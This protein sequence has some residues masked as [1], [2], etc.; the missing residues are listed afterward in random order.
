[1]ERPTT[2]ELASMPEEQR[3]TE[4]DYDCCL[5]S[6]YSAASGMSNWADACNLI[7]RAMGLSGV[8]II[9]LNKHSGQLLFSWEGGHISKECFFDYA[10]QYH[11]QNP[12]LP[13]ALA[14]RGG[15]WFQ[16]H[17]HFDDDFVGINPFYQDFAIPYG[18]RYL[19]A[20]KLIDDK[21]RVV[22]FGALRAANLAPLTQV[23]I[24]ELSRL[25]IHLAQ[26]ATIYL[27]LQDTFNKLTVG[28]DL[29][30]S[31]PYPI[32]TTTLNRE[33]VHQ[34]P[35]AADLMQTDTLVATRQSGF[36]LLDSD[37][38]AAL[39]SRLTEIKQAHDGNGRSNIRKFVI[40]IGR[41]VTEAAAIGIVI[42]PDVSRTSFGMDSLL[43]LLIHEVNQKPSTDPFIVGKIFDLTPAESMVATNLANGS[44]TQAIA[45][46]R[47]VSEHT[48]RAQV[49]SIYTKLNISSHPELTRRL[50]G[51]PQLTPST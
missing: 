41:P 20:T 16:D 21:D 4:E 6:I 38:D 14:L 36:H 49:R 37:G 23:E 24:K 10:T 11:A 8:H 35:R 50:I 33:I 39:E 5:A 32:F 18:A 12:H 25:R 2:A 22:M 15:G 40:A 9:G 45:K 31:L 13:Y 17:L 28:H 29:L 42:D 43:L 51:L 19:S 44:T 27:H 7:S 46:T 48:V 34:N 26:A 3:L 47:G 30:N 1:M